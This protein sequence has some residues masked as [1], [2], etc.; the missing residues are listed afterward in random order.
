MTPRSC[1][2]VAMCALILSGCAQAPLDCGEPTPGRMDP[3]R[4]AAAGP[5]AEEFADAAVSPYQIGMLADGVITADERA[6][7]RARTKVCMREHGYRYEE[8]RDGAADIDPLHGQREGIEQ[9]M[10]YLR[11]CSRRFDHD[12]SRLFDAIRRNP[13]H[14]GEAAL[15]VACLRRAGVVGRDY[16]EQRWRTERED[17]D[18]SFVEWSPEATQCRLDPLGL[19]Q[20]G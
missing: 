11:G 13:E 16:T 10:S 17:D 19:L 7:A 18:Y 12:I 1:A 20:E 2:L 4:F 5:W 6:D 8:H 3:S 9:V 14:R 15:Q